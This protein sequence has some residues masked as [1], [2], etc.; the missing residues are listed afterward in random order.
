MG[1]CDCAAGSCSWKFNKGDVMCVPCA[2]PS[3]SKLKGKG[4][5]TVWNT[6][7]IN[8]WPGGMSILF[9]VKP[10]QKS[11]NGWSIAVDAA[12]PLSDS[13][14][15]ASSMMELTDVSNQNKMFSFTTKANS[16]FWDATIQTRVPIFLT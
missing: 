13:V 14:T 6:K 4:I 12:A 9:L 1:T 10:W 7:M 5:T 16:Q 3:V 11:N 15:V 8:K 2:R